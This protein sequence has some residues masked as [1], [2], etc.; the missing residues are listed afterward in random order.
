MTGVQTCALPIY[1]LWTITAVGEVEVEPEPQPD[2]IDDL[3]GAIDFAL[4]YDPVSGRLHFGADDLS[5]LRFTVRLYDSSGRLQRTFRACD[6]T[7]LAGLP[8]GLYLVTWELDGRR[9]TIK[10]NR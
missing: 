1:R 9:R 6:G 4:A 2:G 8:R 7:T 5:A 10:F 3:D